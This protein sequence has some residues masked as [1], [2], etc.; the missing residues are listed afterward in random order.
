MSDPIELVI[1]P[2]TRP[3]GEGTVERLLP[4]AARRMVGPFIYLDLIGPE[5]LPDGMGLDVPVHPHIGL[6]T[7]TF[8]THGAIVHRDST[9]AVQRIEPG[10]VNWMHAG[11]GVAH[12]E[13][14]PAD[15]RAG[16]ST[17]AGVQL[18]VALPEDAE[19]DEPW[20][21]HHPRSTLPVDTVGDADVQV[22]AGTAY[23][24][25][26]PARVASPLH[27]ASARFAAGGEMPAPE[28]TERA[29]LVLDGD[30]T[31][32]DGTTQ[33]RAERRHLSV[34]AP[35]PITIRTT[36]SASLVLLGGEPV[37]P[38]TISWNFV[39]SDRA[40]IERAE[41]RWRDDEFPAVP[42]ETERVPLPG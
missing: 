4:H 7:V 14:S 12:S 1:P 2:R 34:L 17:L 5:T 24:L 25:A 10:D 40:R 41:Q 39:A 28:A 36:G 11:R 37:G 13:R 38:R 33:V 22:L 27:Y 6:A 29:V 26:S 31:L 19:D 15:Q 16:E 20:F 18:W 30:V 9:G 23:G 42:G 3:V 32:D 35:G 21:E 8:L